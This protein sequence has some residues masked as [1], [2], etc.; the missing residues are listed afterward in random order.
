MIV[1]IMSGNQQPSPLWKILLGILSILGIL[2]DFSSLKLSVTLPEGAFPFLILLYFCTSQFDIIHHVM[3]G[4]GGC[5]FGL[6]HWSESNLR[7]SLAHDGVPGV[8]CAWPRVEYC[9]LTE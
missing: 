2:T 8:Q 5:H 7:A 4:L 6:P 1:L 3:V 9:V